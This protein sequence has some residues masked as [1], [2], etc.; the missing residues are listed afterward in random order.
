MGCE[1]GYI[2]GM[3]NGITLMPNLKTAIS[4]EKRLL[5]AVDDLARE[6]GLPRS[7][8]F[9]RAVEAYLQQ[10]RNQQI[11]NQINRAY[12]EKPDAAE[13]RHLSKMRTKQRKLL[14]DQW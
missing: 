6:Q 12:S 11:L 14:E 1:F 10:H 7:G 3:N 9:A 5:Q 2:S 8:I 13:R 4:I